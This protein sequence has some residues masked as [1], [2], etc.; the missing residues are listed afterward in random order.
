MPSCV[1]AVSCRGRARDVDGIA[2]AVP[3]PLVEAADVVSD[4][5][6]RQCCRRD[7]PSDFAPKVDKSTPAGTQHSQ[8]AR[9]R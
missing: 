7:M 9:A 8:S 1:S 2:G 6:E 4:T 5:P 3:A